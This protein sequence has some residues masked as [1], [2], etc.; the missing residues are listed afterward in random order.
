MP[1]RCIAAPDEGGDCWRACIASVL[2]MPAAMVPNFAHLHPDWDT[3]IAAAREWL[4]PR[5]W[6]IFRSYISAGWDLDDVLSWFSGNNPHVPVIL[7]G[8]SAADP[9]D[10]H[11]VVLLNG[12]IAHD[13]S[14]A[15]LAGP[16][17]NE[18]GEPGW[19][20]YD[21]ICVAAIEAE[22]A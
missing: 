8:Q 10:N 12:R 2:D 14:N 19:W 3:M 7:T 6:S 15:G 9:K 16:C 21:V 20:W 17:V 5:G 22:E 18:K 4:A 11:A 1:Q 13:P